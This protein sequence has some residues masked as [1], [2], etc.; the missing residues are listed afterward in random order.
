[1]HVL[2]CDGTQIVL[3]ISDGIMC[4]CVMPTGPVCPCV[5]NVAAMRIKPKMDVGDII[6]TL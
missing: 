2:V 4:D 6:C 5:F 1:M 3:L